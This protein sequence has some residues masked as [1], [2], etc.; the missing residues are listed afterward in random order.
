M[1]GL[2]VMLREGDVVGGLRTTLRT[3]RHIK[4]AFQGDKNPL[5]KDF[6]DQG[7]NVSFV[8]MSEYYRSGED[9]KKS[10]EEIQNGKNSSRKMLRSLM[11][12]WE[13]TS[14]IFENSARVSYYEYYLSKGYSKSRAAQQARRLADFSKKGEWSSN[15]NAVVLFY[16]AAIQGN[17]YIIENIYNNPK[18]G[19]KILA[20]LATAQAM[21]TALNYIVSEDYDEDENS[22]AQITDYYKSR[23]IIIPIP[24]TDG[25][26][27]IPLPLGFSGIANMGRIA[28][29]ETMN[30]IYD[31]ETKGIPTS[32]YNAVY[33]LW[34][35][36]TPP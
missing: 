28:V 11:K 29:E 1:T 21:F 10:V 13:Q 8:N 31:R 15:I 25:H 6:K 16:N 7:G 4:T 19:L 35:T 32:I 3:F 14:N 22:F 5:Y 33:E 2:H 27:F 34:A 36:S 20:A 26:V 18:R 23:N 30:S 9:I 12:Y 17:S 24:G